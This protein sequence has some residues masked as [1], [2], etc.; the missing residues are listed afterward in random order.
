ML[1]AVGLSIYLWN[2]NTQVALPVVI[3]ASTATLL[4][5]I[6]AISP[7]F[8]ESCP[9]KPAI[10]TEW[11]SRITSILF[12]T[13]FFTFL[14]GGLAVYL[15]LV[16][17]GVLFVYVVVFMFIALMVIAFG[18]FLLL[19]LLFISLCGLCTP[20]GAYQAYGEIFTAVSDA[21]SAL[22][23]RAMDPRTIFRLGYSSFFYDR[24]CDLL[25]TYFNP[26]FG[27]EGHETPMDATTSSILGWM[28]TSGESHLALQAL[29]S[30]DSSLPRESLLHADALPLVLQRLSSRL[31][32]LELFDTDSQRQEHD[33]LLREACLYS[34]IFNF[35]IE[36]IDE[37]SLPPH[38]LGYKFLSQ[39]EALEDSY[40]DV[41]REYPWYHD[42]VRCLN[43]ST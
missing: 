38:W 29:S 4:Y 26:Q 32:A 22:D 37:Q 2:I 42:I 13:P 25:G 31:D 18:V 6:A 24:L 15:I 8:F 39:T 19:M 17:A 3:I 7:I 12:L 16:M 40:Y 10:S 20:S 27:E 21:W 11:L 41:L 36:S 35:L 43:S 23:F 28:I 5:I 34:S 30:A 9:F 14:F 33:R 1:F